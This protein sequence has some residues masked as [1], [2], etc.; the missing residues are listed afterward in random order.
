M[1][2]AQLS[3]PRSS[4]PG[5][6]PGEGEG[7]LIN[8]VLEKLGDGVLLRRC[9]GLATSGSASTGSGPRGLT[10][11]FGYLIACYNGA[12]IAWSGSTPFT[13]TGGLTGSA[14]VT[15]A[16]NLKQPA[17]DLVVC[18]STGGAQIITG[19]SSTSAYPDADLPATVNSVANLSAYFI[20][21]DPTDNKIWASQVNSTDVSALSYATAESAPGKLRRVIRSGNAVL[22]LCEDRIEPWV[23][24]GASPFPL[25]RHT[26]VVPV[27]LL[28]F[29]AIAGAQQGWDRDLLFVAHDGT[30]R[31]LRGYEAAPVSTPDVERFIADSTSGTFDAQVYTDR[32]RSF[33]SLSS[34]RGTWVYCVDQSSWAERQSAG[35]R[36]RGTA[37]CKSGQTWYALDRSSG[38]VLTISAANLS[39][40]SDPLT[41]YAESSPFKAFPLRASIPAVHLDF[42]RGNGGNCEFSFSKDGGRN[43]SDWETASLGSTGE[44]DGPVIFNRLGQ[45][46]THGLRVRVRVSDAVAFSFMGGSF[47][48]FALRPQVEG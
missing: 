18:R 43:W 37:T 15:F 40:V 24:V 13:I 19:A 10:E 26:T 44:D 8:A 17:P 6:L 16:Q 36:W 21:S 25:K 46:S 47:P 2:P 27:G 3:F 34:D 33:W 12:L 22:A 11:Y 48:D 31:Q 1:A 29:G 35:A 5:S 7:R 32:G 38:S 45:A 42:T 20:F 14:P 23:N 4:T 28:E 30:V 39:D 41:F 9:A